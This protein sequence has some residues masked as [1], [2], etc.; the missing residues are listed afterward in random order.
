[1]SS[2]NP[3]IVEDVLLAIPESKAVYSKHW[4]LLQTGHM[5][6]GIFLPAIVKHATVAVISVA[7]PPKE[8]I[9]EAK[10]ATL[11]MIPSEAL[12]L[13][14]LAMLRTSQDTTNTAWGICVTGIGSFAV[15]AAKLLPMAAQTITFVNKI[16][17]MLNWIDG[18]SD[19]TFIE[20]FRCILLDT[21]GVMAKIFRPTAGVPLS[22][23]SILDLNNEVY[24]D[25]E[26]VRAVL[27]LFSESYGSN[28]RYIFISPLQIQLW[29]EDLMKDWK[30]SEIKSGR[31]KKAFAVVHMPGHWG[32]LEVDFVQCKISFG[33]SLSWP[34]P[35]DMIEVVRDWIGCCG[36]DMDQ[37]SC[38]VEQFDVP[39]QPA[40]SGSCAINAINAIEMSINPKTERWTHLKSAHHR[41]RLLKL[42]TGFSKV[43]SVVRTFGIH[44]C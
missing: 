17:D 10:V 31:A 5:L 29:K 24:L 28:G 25:D 30:Q 33:D 35:S 12:A 32:A 6:L 34:V 19:V 3:V 42:V 9:F 20:W 14:A 21:P 27:E 7:P 1:M 44:L 38:R 13:E 4:Q 8:R 16:K 37:W 39:H 11:K 15:S 2:T 18:K 22:I 40:S 43:C 36:G 41:L 23:S 26:I